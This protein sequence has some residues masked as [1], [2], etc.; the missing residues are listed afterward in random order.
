MQRA[1]EDFMKSPEISLKKT[2]WWI[3]FHW[4]APTDQLTKNSPDSISS[5]AR[6]MCRC[7]SHMRFRPYNKHS[8]INRCLPK[9]RRSQERAVTFQS[10][11]FAAKYLPLYVDYEDIWT[12][13]KGRF[14][15]SNATS[16]ARSSLSSIIS[17][18]TSRTCTKKPLW[19]RRPSTTVLVHFLATSKTVE[20]SL[21]HFPSWTNTWWRS[22]KSINVDERKFLR[23]R[24]KSFEK[25]IK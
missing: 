16:V 22:S 19:S 1:K 21:K 25:K 9:L 4:K 20:S 5:S 24:R 13:F 23:L 7:S 8:T 17:R 2:Q 12:Q 6:C 18:N 15:A 14:V 10:V 11:T 3:G